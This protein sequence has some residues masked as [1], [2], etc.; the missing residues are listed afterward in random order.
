[1]TTTMKSAPSR[2]FG[3]LLR[4]PERV[5][6]LIERLPLQH[7]SVLEHNRVNWLLEASDRDVI[8]ILL[9]SK[10]FDL[11]RLGGGLWLLSTNLKEIVRFIV[12]EEGPTR[13]ALLNSMK[14]FAP[15]MFNRLREESLEG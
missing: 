13:D 4:N 3:N 5:K 11:T 15:N 1:M 6:G 9:W 12:S 14:T 8:D 10:F 2:V 7:K